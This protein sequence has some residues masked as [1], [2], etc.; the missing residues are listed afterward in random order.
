MRS[1]MHKKLLKKFIVF[2]I[3]LSLTIIIGCNNKDKEL[4]MAKNSDARYAKIERYLSIAE[5]GL[6]YIGYDELIHFVS[7]D[8]HEDMVFCFNPNCEHVSA[9]FDNPDPECRA[10]LFEEKTKISYYEKEFYY[11]VNNGVFEHKLYRMDIN[12]GGR[13]L[14]AEFPFSYSVAYGGVF[15]E[16]YLYY[17][18]VQK[19]LDEETMKV[20]SYEQLVEVNINDGS[21]RF[22]TEIN[23]EVNEFVASFDISNDTIYALMY[24][25]RDDGWSVPYLKKINLKTLEENII[26]SVEE[27]E[28]KKYVGIYDDESYYYYTEDRKEIRIANTDTGEEKTLVKLNDGEKLRYVM[29]SNNGIVYKMENREGVTR[30]YYYDVLQAVTMPLKEEY[31][32]GIALYDGFNQMC[33][34]DIVDGES[35]VIGKDIIRLEDVLV[36]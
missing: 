2:F 19:E 5:D 27:C 34:I 15:Y 25:K 20:K 17:M 22:I 8:T 1:I 29:A 16:D 21:Y 35:K 10:A 18:A 6:F 3:I 4:E 36:E 7:A 24:K 23:R 31:T 11:F 26:L 13:K 9:T 33:T 12:G 30:Y 28:Y 32:Q 14:I